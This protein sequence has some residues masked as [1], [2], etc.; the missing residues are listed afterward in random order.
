MIPAIIAGM[1]AIIVAL[2]AKTSGT[3]KAVVQSTEQNS[4]EHALVVEALQS[5]N[6]RVAQVHDMIYDHVTDRDL[7]L[8]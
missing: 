2:I 3:K 8:R 7:H 6:G 4:S 5:L 1:T